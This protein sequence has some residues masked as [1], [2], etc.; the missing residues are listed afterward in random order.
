VTAGGNIG[1]VCTSAGTPGTWKT[2]GTIATASD[3]I[4]VKDYGAVGDGV[5]DDTAAIQAAIDAAEA[6][7]VSSSTGC[8]VLVPRGKFLHTGLTINQNGITIRGDGVYNSNLHFTSASGVGV[9]FTKGSS[10]LFNC[11]LR[12]ITLRCTDTASGSK[13]ALSISDAS[14]MLVENVM[15]TQCQGGDSTG[16]RTY[17]REMLTLRNIYV[18]ATIPIRLS[19]NPNDVTTYLSAD[20]FSFENLYLNQHATDPATLTQACLLIDDIFVSNLNVYGYQAWINRKHGVYYRRTTTSR[21]VSYTLNFDNVR[22]EQA[23]DNTGYNFYLDFTTSSLEAQDVQIRNCK[24]SS[25]NNGIYARYIRDLEIDGFS[26]SGTLVGLDVD[27]IGTLTTR[28]LLIVNGASSMTMNSMRLR[29]GGRRT[30]NNMDHVTDG[31]WHY[32]TSS[33]TS[34]PQK[35]FEADTWAWA[36]E[37]ADDGLKQLPVNSNTQKW[38]VAR[39]EAMAMNATSNVMEY[40]LWLVADVDSHGTKGVA[41]VTGTTNTAAGNSDG[42]LCIYCNGTNPL[43]APIYVYNRLGQTCQ[44]CV[45]IVGKRASDA[46]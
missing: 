14:Q 6:Y 4:N 13:T 41:K 27:R 32:E 28:N 40:G 7:V 42:N 21:P 3:V 29:S 5:T 20:H 37:L 24:A 36:G 19:A 38:E 17:G 18:S 33:Q 39:I 1:W 26:K 12:D 22:C 25:E 16:I 10:I 35:L 11:A 45:N 15:I 46:L 30:D 23:D 43:E 31:I 44:V 34:K 2:F 8:S 9:S